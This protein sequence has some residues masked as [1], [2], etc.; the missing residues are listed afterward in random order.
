[1]AYKFKTSGSAS[2]KTLDLRCDV[3]EWISEITIDLRNLTEDE[4]SR[5]ISGMKSGELECVDAD[6]SGKMQYAIIRAPS[7][8]KIGVDG[9]DSQIAAF[10]HR[11]KEEFV[12]RRE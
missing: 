7:F 2:F 8:N 6:C 11:C 10:K 4:K 9:S 1:M 5:V 12:W 3:C